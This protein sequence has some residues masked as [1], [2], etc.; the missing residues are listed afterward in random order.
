M[1]R[2]TVERINRII[3]NFIWDGKPAKIKK[4]TII[5]ERKHGGLKMIDFELKIAWIKRFAENNHAAWKII[6]EHTL[7][8]H[9]GI[10]LL[11]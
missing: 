7:S 3:F 6:P 8:Q 1:S 4:K 10:F 2:R 9:G 11:T 5:A